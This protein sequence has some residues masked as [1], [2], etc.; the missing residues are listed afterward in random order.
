MRRSV[1]RIPRPHRQFRLG[2][3]LA[4]AGLVLQLLLPGAMAFARTADPLASAPIC[5]TGGRHPLGPAEGHKALHAACPLCQGQA[6]VWGFL[7]PD[8]AG[9]AGPRLATGVIWSAEIL[10]ATPVVP[11]ALRARG[12]P[13]VA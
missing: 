2:T 4:L 7:P 6:V 8:A 12:P 3:A 5:T 9:V 10:T 13:A 1:I 11:P